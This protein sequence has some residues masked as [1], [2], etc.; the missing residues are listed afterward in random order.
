MRIGID[1]QSTTTGNFSGLGY[2]TSNLISALRKIDTENEYILFKNKFFYGNLSVPKRILWEQIILPSQVFAKEIDILHIPAFSPPMLLMK[3]RRCKVVVTLHDLIGIRMPNN[4]LSLSSRFYWSRYL[5]WMARDADIVITDSDYSKKDIMELLTIPEKKVKVIYLS[6]SEIFHPVDDK[7]KIKYVK[8][9]YNIR[10]GEEYIL[11]VGNIEFRKN[12]ILLVEIWEKFQI[13]HKL[14]LAG[15]FTKYA[16]TLIRT[17]REKR[18]EDKIIFTGYVPSEEL[19]L[20]YNGALLF[21]YPSLYEGFGLPVLE[22]M[23]CGVPVV[24]SNVTALP[25]IVGNAGMLASPTDVDE[26]GYAILEV[27]NST[28]LRNALREKGFS[29]VKAFSWEKTAKE[30]LEVYKMLK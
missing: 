20:L 16:Q 14:L 27:L 21:V 17:V 18:L 2:Y 11:Y 22:A 6:A 30:T 10:E 12:L 29:R 5:E 25:E 3:S 26:F 24:T 8:A 4:N 13:E 23:S 15:A 19:L 7:E 28:S 9:K 1:I